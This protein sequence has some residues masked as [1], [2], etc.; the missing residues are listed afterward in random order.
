MYIYAI[1]STKN[2]TFI[3]GETNVIGKLRQPKHPVK[4]LNTPIENKTAVHTL[5]GDSKYIMKHVLGYNDQE[6]HDMLE[7]GSL[8]SS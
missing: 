5:G 8:L 2:K 7:D 3:T 4:F 1:H 6:I